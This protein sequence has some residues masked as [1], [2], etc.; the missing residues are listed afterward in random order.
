MT[1][2]RKIIYD[3]LAMEKQKIVK[4]D[5]VRRGGHTVKSIGLKEVKYTDE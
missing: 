5:R 3:R 4:G 1:V 2:N